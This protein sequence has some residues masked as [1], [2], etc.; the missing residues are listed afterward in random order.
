MIYIISI[1]TV[2]ATPEATE[3]AKSY[4]SSP[5]GGSPVNDWNKKSKSKPVDS[6]GPDSNATSI[7]PVR[8][9]SDMSR[10]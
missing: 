5:T 8:K 1:G 4:V 6:A 2:Q 9:L 3:A 7:P 10:G